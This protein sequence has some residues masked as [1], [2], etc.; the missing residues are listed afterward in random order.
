MN[1]GIQTLRK[2][3]LQFEQPF[4]N[5]ESQ[6]IAIFDL[7]MTFI[8]AYLLEPYIRFY[9]KI[10]R[11]AYYLMLIPLGVISHIFTKQETFLNKQLFSHSINVY[12]IIMAIIIYQLIKE[13][14]LL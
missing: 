3:R 10:S 11:I 5:T 8:I 4:F 12:Q 14:R 7:S 1:T 6:G 13:L 9:L 2:Y